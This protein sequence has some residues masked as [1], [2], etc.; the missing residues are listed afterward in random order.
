MSEPIRFAINGYKGR[1]GRALEAALT[2]QEQTI[3]TRYEAG[4][5]FDLSNVDVVID[6]TTPTATL[7]LL[8]AC[9][10]EGLSRAKP[11]VHIIGTTG[12][13]PEDNERI[14]LLADQVIIVKSGNFSL[15]INIITGLL[16]QASA[17]LSPADWDIEIFE[18]HHKRKVDA[19]SGTALM[20]GEA[21]ALGRGQTLADIKVAA[22]DGITGAREDG[23]IGFSVMRGGGIVGE[24][25]A[26]LISEEE[27]I[28]L[29]HSARDRSLFAKGAVRAAL[30]A[31]GQKAGL[32]DMQD[33]L[34]F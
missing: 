15:G 24:H 6:F 16:R 20:L 5:G 22:R 4:D 19:P 17:L 3:T 25:A 8:E 1:M 2:A 21:A 13:S 7:E 18:A 27:I 29:S 10:S 12:L 33:V 9:A 31:C 14:S 34:G 28:T 26:H 32:Y 11:L 30:W 23:T